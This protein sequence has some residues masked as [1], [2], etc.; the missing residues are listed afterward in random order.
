MRHRL[1]QLVVH[2]VADSFALRRECEQSHPAI[3]GIGDTDRSNTCSQARAGDPVNQA[4][5][6]EWVTATCVGER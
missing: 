5:H 1:R 3:A 6:V 2:A 4:G